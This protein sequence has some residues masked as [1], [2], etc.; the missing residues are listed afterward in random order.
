V[1][2]VSLHTIM[3][4]GMYLKDQGLHFDALMV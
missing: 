2:I 1:Q 4:S 3:S